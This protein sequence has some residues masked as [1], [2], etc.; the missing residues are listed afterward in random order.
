MDEAPQRAWPVARASWCRNRGHPP[1][2]LQSGRPIGRGGPRSS[3]VGGRLG[4]QGAALCKA[5]EAPSGPWASSRAVGIPQRSEAWRCFHSF[6]T[7]RTTRLRKPNQLLRSFLRSPTPAFDV[8]G[9]RLV[10][11]WTVLAGATSNLLAADR[12]C[13]LQ[14]TRASPRGPR[15]DSDRTTNGSCDSRR[16][17]PAVAQRQ[18]VSLAPQMAERGRFFGQDRP[19]GTLKAARRKR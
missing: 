17:F 12:E 4:D 13:R 7:R 9:A 5:A 1:G 8:G 19:K 15:P 3:R 10:T 16:E 2:V 14:G 18:A 11:R 6:S